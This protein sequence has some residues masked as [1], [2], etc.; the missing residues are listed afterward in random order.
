MRLA[1]L[2]FVI[3]ALTTVGL[4]ACASTPR[5]AAPAAPSSLAAAE[6]PCAAGQAQSPI[7]IDPRDARPSQLEAPE[8]H[9]QPAGV[10]LWNNGKTVQADYAAGVSPGDEAA[11]Y[12][13][14]DGVRFD[15]LQFHF[16]RPVEHPIAGLDPKPVLEL[17][18]VHSDSHGNLAVVAVPVVIGDGNTGTLDALMAAIPRE[19]GWR[20]LLPA[21]FDAQALAPP[22]TAT[23]FRYPG[24]LTTPPFAEC[25]RWV[26]Y[27]DALRI[28]RRSFETYKDRFGSPHSR[29]PQRLNGRVPLRT[30]P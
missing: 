5:G 9:Y 18:L 11:N 13:L 2:R 8:L 16:H 1:R 14:L 26:V 29:S 7:A 24:S 23:A 4:G 15:L 3:V 19:K 28:S 25:V 21:R 17:H 10:V 6:E 20:S 30:K 27:T 12:I 22:R